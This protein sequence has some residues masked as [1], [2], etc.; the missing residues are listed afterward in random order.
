MMCKTKHLL[1]LL[2]CWCAAMAQA[3]TAQNP[4]SVVAEYNLKTDGTFEQGD[5]LSITKAAFLNGPK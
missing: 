5:K 2:M 3:Q 1:M 4:L